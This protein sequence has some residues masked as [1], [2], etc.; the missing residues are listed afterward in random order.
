MFNFEYSSLIAEI[1]IE[2]D[3][4]PTSFSCIDRKGL[5]CIISNDSNLYIIHIQAVT[6]R[7]KATFICK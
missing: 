3:C 1:H 2:V 5:V 7:V 6:E 4:F